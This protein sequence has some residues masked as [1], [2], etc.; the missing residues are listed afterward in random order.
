MIPV[1]WYAAALAAVLLLGA[2][3]ALLLSGLA[4]AGG[5][6]L[7]LGVIIAVRVWLA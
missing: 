5:I 7:A 2:G 3:M 6:L 4:L 1:P